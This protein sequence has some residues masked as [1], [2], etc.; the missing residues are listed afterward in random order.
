MAA[1]N[2]VGRAEQLS[3]IPWSRGSVPRGRRATGRR[4]QGPLETIAAPLWFCKRAQTGHGPQCYTEWCGVCCSCAPDELAARALIVGRC[5]CLMSGSRLRAGAHKERA[6][7][8]RTHRGNSSC[9][10]TAKSSSFLMVKSTTA[11]MRSARSR[12]GRGREVE[13]RKE[14][15]WG[16]AAGDQSQARRWFRHHFTA[17]SCLGADWRVLSTRR[18]WALLGAALAAPSVL[19]RLA[20]SA[21]SASLRHTARFGAGARAA[22]TCVH[23]RQTFAGR[24]ER[25][26][27]SRSGIARAEFAAEGH[28]GAGSHRHGWKGGR[29]PRAPV[30]VLTT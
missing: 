12:G 6:L 20:R 16:T 23:R 3:T 2:E 26:P 24:C 4:L 14:Q 18:C 9:E 22:L 13:D 30:L 28:H 5:R 10:M 7:L 1:A 8:R 15:Q 29:G 19:R 27:N 21:V 11:M 17:H 25:R